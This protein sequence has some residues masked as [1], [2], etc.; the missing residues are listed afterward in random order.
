MTEANHKVTL[1]D[2]L[3]YIDQGG[4]NEQIIG[5]VLEDRIEIDLPGQ[6]DLHASI[7]DLCPG[8]PVIFTAKH[9]K[10]EE[11]EKLKEEK[12]KEE[13]AP[14]KKAAK[15]KAAKKKVATK[16]ELEVGPHNFKDP[17]I[18]RILHEED[19]DRFKE[20]YGLPIRTE[21]R[22]IDE[23]GLSKKEDTRYQAE[24]TTVLTRQTIR[25]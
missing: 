17:A 25:K 6:P 7:E 12:A 9:M 1:D 24:W 3:F 18:V 5:E 8:K 19:F 2:D 22:P 21:K 4:E 15:K 13:A 16:L 23:V 10:R 11:V 20:V 14:K